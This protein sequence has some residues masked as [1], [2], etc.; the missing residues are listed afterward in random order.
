MSVLIQ[1]RKA[2][3]SHP[4]WPSFI[5]QAV[6][7][8]DWWVTQDHAEQCH[9]ALHCP[10]AQP[11]WV[12]RQQGGVGDNP[13]GLAGVRCWRCVCAVCAAGGETEEEKIRVDILENQA[14]DVSNQLARVCYSPDFVSLISLPPW[15]G[16]G[17][18]WVR[19]QLPQVPNLHRSYLPFEFLSLLPSRMFHV[20]SSAVPMTL[21]YQM[22]ALT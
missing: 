13:L 4:V 17:S 2:G 10:Q 11:V 8:L 19:S 14:M 18:V 7:L 5:V 6:A 15:A 12:G 20:L 22:N 21:N 1:R 16:P 9:P 3:T